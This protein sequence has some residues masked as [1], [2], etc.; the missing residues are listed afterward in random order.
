MAYKILVSEDDGQFS[1]IALT[2]PGVFATGATKREARLNVA[3][4]IRL[5]VEY[6]REHG[7]VLP[8]S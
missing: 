1:A 4:A 2:L 5:Y 6:A 8:K 7:L 3:E